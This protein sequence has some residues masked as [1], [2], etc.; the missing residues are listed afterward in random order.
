[1]SELLP[2]CMQVYNVHVCW[3]RLLARNI[4]P[5]RRQNAKAKSVPE[6][7]QLLST[8]HYSSCVL[9]PKG[10]KQNAEAFVGSFETSFLSDLSFNGARL[11][12]VRSTQSNARA[13]LQPRGDV[14]VRCLGV[15]HG[16]GYGGSDGSYHIAVTLA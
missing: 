8:Y 14:D 9:M 11:P 1:M 2:K 4:K 16:S 13:G 10:P 6:L 12:F 15:P 5:K 3:H 7:M